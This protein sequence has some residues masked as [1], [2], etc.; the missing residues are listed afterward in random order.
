MC[1]CCVFNVLL[2]H[3]MCKFTSRQHYW[4]FST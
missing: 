4:V 1:L 2:R 3:T